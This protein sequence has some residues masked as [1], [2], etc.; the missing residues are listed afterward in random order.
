MKQ[1]TRPALNSQPKKIRRQNRLSRFVFTLNN[2]TDDELASIKEYT[3]K[4]L[5]IGKEVA[6]S[7][8]IKHLQGACVIGKQTA[9]STI[10]KY[11]G[12]TRAHIE[13]M[14]GRPSDSL[15]YCSKEDTAPFMKG[16]MPQPGKRNDIHDVVDLMRAGRTLESIIEDPGEASIVPLI[17]Y[18]RGFQWVASILTTARTEPPTVVWLHGKTG[19]GKT[20]C[21]FELGSKLGDYIPP[22]VSSGSLRWFDGYR[23]QS[24]AIFDDLR[25]KHAPFH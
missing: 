7:T 2:Y 6:P 8:G 13:P 12:F 16:T 10:K 3:C 24:V 21:A 9:F 25:T 18:Q 14:K 19:V 4:W 15:Q 23:G 17:K 22:W 11:P 20:R 1:A 5:I